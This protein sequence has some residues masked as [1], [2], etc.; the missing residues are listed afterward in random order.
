MARKRKAVDKMPVHTASAPPISDA[1]DPAAKKRKIDWSTVD[2]FPGFKVVAVDTKAPKKQTKALTTQKKRSANGLENNKYPGH[3]A[4]LDADIVEPNQ[5]QDMQL[6]QVHV[7]ILPARY[8]ESTNRYRKFTINGEEFQ[9][10]QMVF[11][12][13][14]EQDHV[15]EGPISV[16]H[17]LAKVLEVRAG[18]A[19]HVYLRVFWAYRPEDLPGGRQPH[20]GG[21]ELIVS[22]HMDVIEAVT[23]ES[24]ANV[25]HWNDKPE[26][27]ELPADQLFF[28]QSFDITKKTNRLSKLNTYCIDKQPSNPDELLVQCPHCREWL[29][30]GCLKQRA[31]QDLSA[32]QAATPSKS[33]KQSRLS[34]SEIASSQSEAARTFEAKMKGGSKTR[35]TIIEK[36][37]GKIKRKWNVDISCLMC[38]KI[39]EKAGDVASEK[40]AP[41]T[42]APQIGDDADDKDNVTFT[43]TSGVGD[44]PIRDGDA[45]SVIGDADDYRQVEIKDAPTTDTESKGPRK[46]GRPLGSLGKKRKRASYGS[47]MKPTLPHTKRLKTETGREDS[48][49]DAVQDMA[50]SAVVATTATMAFESREDTAVAFEPAQDATLAFEAAKDATET[51][52]SEPQEEIPTIA[53]LRTPTPASMSESVFQSGIRSVKRLLWRT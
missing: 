49:P 3:L 8:W 29:H 41:S 43:K 40:P 30:A 9:V 34:K 28:R 37:E 12:R 24:I 11:V 53:T 44:T 31:L 25:V 47:A 33:K 32:K 42:A 39:I 23:V 18:D 46:R 6:G 10:G 20:H 7:K 35:L 17:W 26:D 14:S 48:P 45:D 50:T 27:M 16:Q 5:F 52:K 19:S 2:N 1:M 21:A 36:H 51:T 38:S 22:N 15:E 13:K 4:P